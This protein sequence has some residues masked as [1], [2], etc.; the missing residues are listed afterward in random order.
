[1]TLVID[2]D[3]VFS[4]ALSAIKPTPVP[5]LFLTWQQLIFAHFDMLGHR[6]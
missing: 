6:M 2:V 4:L 1:M 3:H 5:W